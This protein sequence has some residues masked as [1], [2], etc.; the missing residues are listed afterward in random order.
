[1]KS[2]KEIFE[3]IKI[4]KTPL[5]ENLKSFMKKEFKGDKEY[6]T[7]KKNAKKNVDDIPDF[8][9]YVYGKLGDEIIDELVVKY[10][11][12]ISKLAVEMLK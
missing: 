3:S 2:M 10:K 11:L 9:D 5:E 8:L 7:L 4:E 6:D 12:D 1:M